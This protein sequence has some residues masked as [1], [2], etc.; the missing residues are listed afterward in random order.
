FLENGQEVDLNLEA[1]RFLARAARLLSRGYLVLIDYGC[2]ARE[3][4]HPA[5]RRGTLRAYHRH[6]V[7]RDF[8]LRPG[9][10][11]LTAPLD[12]TALR[13]AAQS[14]GATCLGLTTQARFLLALGALDSLE[15]LD[16]ILRTDILSA[17]PGAARQAAQRVD[18]LRE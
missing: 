9:G 5:R 6:R 10:Q 11:D 17:G 18:P 12:F 8:L 15:D 4:Y 1:G 2:E 16:E 3:L 14:A 7:G 13:R